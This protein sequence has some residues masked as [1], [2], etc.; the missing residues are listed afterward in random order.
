MMGSSRAAAE[1]P[2]D[3]GL[4]LPATPEPPAPRADAPSPSV[5]DV[6]HA[7]VC[8]R[9]EGPW[10]T[11]LAALVES[12]LRTAFG[13][14]DV[15]V[16][17]TDAPPAIREAAPLLTLRLESESFE[18]VFLS[19][20][21]RD[22]PPLERELKLT[23]FPADGR[24]LA[25]IVAADELL[26]ASREQPTVTAT[27]TAPAR[28][29]PEPAPTVIR[30]TPSGPREPRQAIA[31]GFAIEHYGGGQTQLGP[32]LSWRLRFTR[33]LYFAVAGQPRRGLVAAGT[34]GTVSSQLLGG[35]VALG[36]GMFRPRLSLTADLGVRGG[37]IW[38]E[39][40]PTAG[41]AAVGDTAAAWL[42]YA[43][44]ALAVELRVA[45]WLALRVGGSVGAPLVAQA[46]AEGTRDVTAASGV[47]L[48]AQAAALVV[49]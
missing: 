40:D 25:L 38:F 42:A 13:R 27:Q 48:G 15:L 14:R 37:R 39:G 21:P 30:A 36:T 6:N 47:A 24:V 5:R 34:M 28:L 22:R 19:L 7:A 43:D 35:R 31:V 26:Q 10:S 2:S 45:G 46:A 49:F 12:D 33:A 17:A 1:A 16:C 41:S 8:L 11:A 9:F 32:D 18:K 29:A 20:D 3:P 4:P 23:P 44:A